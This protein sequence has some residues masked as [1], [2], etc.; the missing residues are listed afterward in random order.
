VKVPNFGAS[1]CWVRQNKQNKTDR[2]RGW[3]EYLG[4]SKRREDEIL[5][6]VANTE[7]ELIL[8]RI[9]ISGNTILSFKNT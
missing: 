9:H 1:E 2:Q 4:D 7:R 8:C 3:K 6:N 5:K